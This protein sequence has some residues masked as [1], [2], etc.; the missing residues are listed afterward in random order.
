MKAAGWGTRAG[1]AFH[2]SLAIKLSDFGVTAA[3]H[4][5]WKLRLDLIALLE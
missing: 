2:G 1:L 4:D 5:E 3:G